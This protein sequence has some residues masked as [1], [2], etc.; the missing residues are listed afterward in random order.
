MR[1]GTAFP[2]VDEV[3]DRNLKSLTPQTG[4]PQ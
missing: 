2:E 3:Y 4:T 1:T